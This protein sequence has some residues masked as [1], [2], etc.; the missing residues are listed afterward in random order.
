M[1]PRSRKATLLKWLPSHWLITRVEEAGDTVYLTFDDGPDPAWTPTLLDLLR[2]HDAK[3]TFFLVGKLAEAS[4]ALVQRIVD[5]GHRL[6]NHSWHHRQFHLRSIQ[7]QL[8]EI[9]RTD[10][11]L[12]QFDGK[13]RHDFRPPRGLLGW[14]M[15]TAL[16]RKR[17][18]V[19]Y[20]SYDSLDHRDEDAAAIIN[21]F[22]QHPLQSG[23]I[24]LMHDDAGKAIE[25]LKTM[26]PSWCANG[27]RFDGLPLMEAS[28][29]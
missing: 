9:E 22:K 23:D 15:L 7:E 8:D 10:Q 17:T 6:G 20:W 3:A 1:T 26:L 14:Q 5:E 13:I 29:K 16:V 25:A 2:T 18:R 27:W 21:L 12:Q 24:V 4:P 19:A 11:L 28:K